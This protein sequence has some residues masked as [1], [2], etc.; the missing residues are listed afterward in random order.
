MISRSGERKN[1]PSSV[2][3]SSWKKMVD[4]HGQ[5]SKIK[6]T[7]KRFC[8]SVNFILIKFQ[9]SFASPFERP[10]PDYRNI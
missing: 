6:R 2:I 3:Y 1:R 7:I 10:I 9:V 8:D 4:K 5:K